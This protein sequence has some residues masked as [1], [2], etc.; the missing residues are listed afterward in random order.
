[1]NKK[2]LYESIMKDV[3]K[4]VKKHLN[5]SE[6]NMS[7]DTVSS[8]A[9]FLNK[10]FTHDDSYNR[11]LLKT[12]IKLGITTD[13]EAF[14]YDICKFYDNMDNFMQ[15]NPEMVDLAA[16]GDDEDLDIFINDALDMVE[17]NLE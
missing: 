16:Y 15:N 8:F 10:T 9:D 14:S 1:M 13:G 12:I 5:E 6:V 17:F 7:Y 11:E 4:S 3:S 2:V